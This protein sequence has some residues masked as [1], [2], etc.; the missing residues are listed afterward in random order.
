MNELIRKIANTIVAGLDNTTEIGLFRGRMG[1]A[2]FLY[3]YARYSGSSVYERMADELIDKIYGQLK[4]G[5]S[6]SIIDGSAGIGVGLSYLLQNHFIEGD[7]DNIL[8]DLDKKLID[9]SEDVLFKEITSA[10]PVFSSGI[11]LLSRLPLCSAGQKEKWVTNIINTGI[12]FMW[13][14]II[15]RKFEP[16]LSLLNSMFLVYNQLLKEGIDE[17]NVLQLQK[18]M[19]RLSINAIEKKY[20]QSFDIVLLKYILTLVPK[21]FCSD[22]QSRL[23]LLLSDINMDDFNIEEWNN[24]LWW[25]FIY[26][27]TPLE[28]PME[29]IEKYVDQKMLDYSFDMDNINN[30]FSVLGLILIN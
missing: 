15:R 1:L 17:E 13:K 5:I 2:V 10:T 14:I 26:G 7:P 25:Y 19:L 4:P 22:D 12:S 11:Y 23:D 20:Y 8:R 18:D 6:F 29:V 16:K 21:D 3:D 28:Y 9:N 30:Q 27:I 24:N